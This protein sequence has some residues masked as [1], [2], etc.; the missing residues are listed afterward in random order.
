MLGGGPS[1][2]V[3]KKAGKVRLIPVQQSNPSYPT[4]S[5][6]AEQKTDATNGFL[7]KLKSKF[8][9]FFKFGKKKIVRANESSA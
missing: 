2:K 3:V 4:E 1:S 9:A 8:A 5:L 7:S 6:M